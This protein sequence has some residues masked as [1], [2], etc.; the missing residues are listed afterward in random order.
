MIIFSLASGILL[1]YLASPIINIYKANG[2]QEVLRV[3]LVK[4]LYLISSLL[5]W[6]VVLGTIYVSGIAIILEIDL[7]LDSPILKVL[8]PT[9]IFII[10]YICIYVNS[11]NITLERKVRFLHS[12]GKMYEFLFLVW[13]INM[14]IFLLLVLIS[15]DV[16]YVLI[17]KDLDS[18]FLDKYFVW[19]EGDTGG[20]GFEGGS[21][22]PEGGNPGGPS[23]VNE[24]LLASSL[25]LTNEELS[26]WNL[27]REA[28]SNAGVKGITTSN[29]GDILNPEEEVLLAGWSKKE[30][31]F[32]KLPNGQYVL[33]EGW[34]PLPELITEYVGKTPEEL[35]TPRSPIEETNRESFI[36][37][38]D[39]SDDYDCLLFELIDSVNAGLEE[40]NFISQDVAEE[41][42]NKLIDYMG[43]QYDVAVNKQTI[44]ML[45]AQHGHLDYHLGIR[46]GICYLLDSEKN[47]V[48]KSELSDLIGELKK[49]S[50]EGTELQNQL[51]S[52][53]IKHPILRKFEGGLNAKML[54]W[55]D[56][57][58]LTKEK[59]AVQH[60]LDQSVFFDKYLRK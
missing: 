45:R 51:T 58:I 8:F 22:L 49:Q 7:C 6:L 25:S 16:D 1:G 50:V 17:S 41:Y 23:G 47:K 34:K 57:T 59:Y 38:I 55:N 24:A 40:C 52:L 21:P 10:I 60:A 27:E 28:E 29:L 5:Q 30:V 42:L 3:C 37:R 54:R 12:I 31:I 20:S 18:V 36:R 11:V 32:I 43:V 33:P 56:I 48:C 19:M 53:E 9:I 2:L 4:G 14:V 15:I 26:S 44:S 13:A 35:K 46:K 39:N